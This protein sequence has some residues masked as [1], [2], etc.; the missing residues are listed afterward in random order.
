MVDHSVETVKNKIQSAA[1][2]WKWKIWSWKI[3]FQTKV[4][5]KYHS[6]QTNGIYFILFDKVPQ[7]ATNDR[8]NYESVE[9]EPDDI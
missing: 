9:I 6:Y 8:S 1:K 3:L 5:L 4:I 2:L 7:N